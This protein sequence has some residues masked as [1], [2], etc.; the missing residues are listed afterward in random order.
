M[1]TAILPSLT[2]DSEPSSS[3]DANTGLPKTNPV[4][5]RGNP[6]DSALSIESQLTITPERFAESLLRSRV[7]TPDLSN[8]ASHRLSV[9]TYN[10]SSSAADVEGGAFGG[11]GEDYAQNRNQNSGKPSKLAGFVGLFT[12]C[13]ALVAL[14]MFLPLP[15]EFGRKD[16]VTMAEAVADS[17]Y[18]VAVVA[19]FVAVFVFFGLRG[20]RGEDGK[21]WR[22]LFNIE[23]ASAASRHDEVVRMEDVIAEGPLGHSGSASSSLSYWRLLRDSVGLGFTDSNIAIGYLG[24]FV[25]RASTVAIS[26]FMPLF[27]NSFY[28]GN[29]F[30]QGSPNDPSP[31]LKKECRAAY[32]LASILTGVAQLMGLICAPV[33]GYLS[34]RPG[35]INIP[36]VVA[37]TFGI[38]GYIVFPLLPSPE[39]KNIDGRGGTPAVFLVATLIGISQIGAI[40]CSL[41]ALG[42]GVL[43]ADHPSV[44]TNSNAGVVSGAGFDYAAPNTD[45]DAREGAPLLVA[46]ARDSLDSDGEEDSEDADTIHELVSSPRSA[47]RSR[48]FSALNSSRPPSWIVSS[49]SSTANAS[50]VVGAA[51]SAEENASRIRLKGSVAGVYSWCGGAAILLLTKLGGYL[52]DHVSKG[53]PFYMMAVFNGLL[54]IASLAIDARRSLQKLKG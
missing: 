25:A 20:L 44:A 28:I 9:D 2:D 23:S 48:A 45:D 36:I 27:I 17:F 10:G 1:V 13:G 54:L 3:A 19:L 14:T 34:S 15:A 21:G 41:G 18:V 35:R 42:K 50:T 29:G 52:F 4:N 8:R 16:G 49:T 7:N 32:V 33:F 30:C 51:P 22:M 24:G 26:L 46:D 47:A 12:G 53:A 38:A 11:D 31:E 43:S 40:V 37:T 6:R 39:P 5:P